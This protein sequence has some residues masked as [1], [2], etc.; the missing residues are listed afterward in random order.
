ML[1][2]LCVVCVRVLCVFVYCDVAGMCSCIA[3]DRFFV[4]AC[5]RSIVSVYIF[6]YTYVCVLC[7]SDWCVCIVWVCIKLIVCTDDSRVIV[8]QWECRKQC[9][10]ESGVC[11]LGVI[12]GL[13]MNVVDGCLSVLCKYMSPAYVHTH[14]DTHTRTHTHAR[15]PTSVSGAH[16]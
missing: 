15:I 12:V 13:C 1:C 3:I 9:I 4:Q 8:V 11:V 2:V 10:V 6:V 5:T 16:M 14:L 7:V